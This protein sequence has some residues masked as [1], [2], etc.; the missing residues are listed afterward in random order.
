V[1]TRS[2]A[3]R[4]TARILVVDDEPLQLHSA[5]RILEH[6]GYEVATIAS[7][8]A[9]YERFADA[10]G[11]AD[12]RKSPFDLVILDMMLG[13]EHDGLEILRRV[14]ELFP[15][16]RGLLM[17]GHA[18]AER[19]ELAREQGFGWLAK[20]FGTDSLANAVRSVLRS[21]T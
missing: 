20:P 2:N 9:A 4:G 21:E 14:R 16:Q 3:P 6:L 8:Q 11:P 12:G 17:S 15:G 7:G 18:P 10:S 19:G 13:E 1:R 5:R